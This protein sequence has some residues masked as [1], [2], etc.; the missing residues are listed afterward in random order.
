MKHRDLEIAELPGK[1]RCTLCG[2]RP[3]ESRLG[4]SMSE[5]GATP[6][7]DAELSEVRAQR[8]T[9]NPLA[10]SVGS[11]GRGGTVFSARATHSFPCFVYWKALEELEE[12]HSI[13]PKSLDYES[14]RR[15][16]MKA[17]GGIPLGRPA[18]AGEVA[19]L[20]A[21]LVS[22]RAGAISGAECVIDGGTVPTV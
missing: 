20:I 10:P 7:W 1:L 21:F 6:G 8:P 4:W 2:H 12:H 3:A 15:I 5:Q 18:R 19:D 14:G 17:L 16:I 22:A 11:K 9:S 13:T